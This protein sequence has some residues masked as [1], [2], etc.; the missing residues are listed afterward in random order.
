MAKLPALR[1]DSFKSEVLDSPQPVLVDFHATWCGPC[2]ALA[3]TLEA[4]SGEFSGK[5]KFMALDI[6]EARMTAQ[7]YNV[8]TVP[9]MLIFKQGRV[10]KQMIG[11]RPK[12]EI[13]DAIQGALSA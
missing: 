12:S 11:N 3:P 6:D 4:L 8:M 1:D 10:V 13:S 2:K 5:V 7:E 9:T